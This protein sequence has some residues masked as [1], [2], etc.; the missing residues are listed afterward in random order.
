MVPRTA[1]LPATVYAVGSHLFRAVYIGEFDYTGSTSATVS[2]SDVLISTTTALVSSLNPSDYSQAVTFTATVSPSSNAGPGPGGSVTF[3]DG[4]TVLGTVPVA[5]S[6]GHYTASIM[7]S[8]LA[9]GTHP[10]TASYGGSTDYTSSASS[11]L[12]QVV[13]KD[14][15]SIAG[16]PLNNGTM[17]ATLTNAQGGP[18]SGGAVVLDREHD[19]VRRRDQRRGSGDLHGDRPQGSPLGP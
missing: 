17:T 5:L 18:I 13:S 16:Q 8:G 15:T 11:T 4:S 7:E 6:G 3:S 9:V 19:S 14:A 12:S 1:T 10:I 2:Q